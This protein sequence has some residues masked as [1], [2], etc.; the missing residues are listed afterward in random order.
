MAEEGNNKTSNIL[1]ENDSKGIPS[2]LTPL[3]S[4]LGS[5]GGSY[6]LW[7]KPLQDNFK[8][9]A[10]QIETLKD[11]IREIKHKQK[12]VDRNFSNKLKLAMEGL[13]S[14]TSKR[15]DDT[16]E[17]DDDEDELIIPSKK[18]KYIKPTK[19]KKSILK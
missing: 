11:E 9:M 1:D 10:E 18:E 17:D 16:E 8:A 7:V 3:L 5:M 13:E 14:E 6:M 15:F 12:E 4:G 2:W 19:A